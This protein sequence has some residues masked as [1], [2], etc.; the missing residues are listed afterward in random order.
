MRKNL[1]VRI[2]K[3][4][5]HCGKHYSV[6]PCYAKISK[7]CSLAC[8]N[9]SKKGVCLSKER[10]E[11]MRGRTPWNKGKIN[12]ITII[13]K[14]CNKEFN[15]WN[16]KQIYCSLE[17]RI[18]D[19]IGKNHH[20]WKGGKHITKRGYV[21]MCVK[22][23]PNKH[24]SYYPEH[25]LVMEKHLGRYLKRTEVVHHI[26][27]NKLD[28]RIENLMLFPNNGVHRCYHRWHKI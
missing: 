18:K 2:G 22:D 7:H 5:A 6:H 20:Q 8:L 11:K 28:N 15:T 3:I 25:R 14:A 13:C 23:H 17:C 4:C 1:G 9:K 27:G 26:N 21:A 19:K 24:N 10:I 12:K 16:K